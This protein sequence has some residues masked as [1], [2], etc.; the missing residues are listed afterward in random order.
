MSATQQFARPSPVRWGV[1]GPGRVAARFA[2]GLAG[3]QGAALIYVWGRDPRRAAE[4][5]QRFKL[6]HVAPT[7]DAFL[8][9]PI[10]AV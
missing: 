4:F 10:D 2:Q 3:V 5:A 1:I 8:A 9:S 6:N 7:I